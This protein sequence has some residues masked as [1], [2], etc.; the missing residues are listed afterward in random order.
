MRRLVRAETAVRGRRQ[1][2]REIRERQLRQGADIV[3]RE[4]Y[5]ERLALQAFAFAR[6][7]QRARHETRDPL[8]HEGALRRR[9]GLQHVL[10]GAGKGSHVAGVLLATQRAARLRGCVARIHG[11]RRLLVGEQDPIAILARQFA[12]G[13]VDVVAQAHQDVAQI[14]PVPGGRPGGDRA[15][16]DAQ[17]VVRHHRS[18][19]H[20]VH[21]AEA[22]A[23]RASALRC[24][25]G[26]ILRM[27]HRTAT[28]VRA[29]ARVQHAQKIGERRYAAHRG[30]CARGAALL[31]QGDR[32]RQS[33]DGVDIGHA[34]LIDEAARIG[35]DRFEITPLRLRVQGAESKR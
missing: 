34:D 6:R 28:P 2:T 3:A 17:R 29:G 27:Q 11:H 32:G 14:L 26:E 19:R 15:V 4:Q 16:A 18:L 35:R 25:R 1:H 8:L 20:F 24:I 31:L 23:V 10:T 7:A 12:P 13:R 30:A 21:I 33:L 22:M 5:L 9:E